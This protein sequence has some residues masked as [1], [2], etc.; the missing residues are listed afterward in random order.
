MS[1]EFLSDNLEPRRHSTE[2]ELKKRWLD[3]QVSHEEVRAAVQA[4]AD[5]AYQ[6]HLDSRYTNVELPDWSDNDAAAE[7]PIAPIEDR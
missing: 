3:D 7:A 1:H 2:A 6:R 5:A 4:R